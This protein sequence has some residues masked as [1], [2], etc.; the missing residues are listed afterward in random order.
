MRVAATRALAVYLAARIWNVARKP[1]HPNAGTNDPK[2]PP[3]NPGVSDPEVRAGMMR[4]FYAQYLAQGLHVIVPYRELF[5]KLNLEPAQG[6][7][8]LEY[9][10]AKG[11]VRIMTPDGG[12]SPTVMLVDAIEAGAGK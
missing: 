12:Y 11:Y 9:L 1:S 8:C 10:S 2:A 4:E 3:P 5:T 7:R 6:R